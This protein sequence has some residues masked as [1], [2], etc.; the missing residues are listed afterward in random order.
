MEL[1]CY[2][3]W[4]AVLVSQFVRRKHMLKENMVMSII[5]CSL[6]TKS[7]LA[8]SNLEFNHGLTY[9]LTYQVPS[10]F[11]FFLLAGWSGFVS[12]TSAKYRHLH[13]PTPHHPLHTFLWPTGAT[14]SRLWEHVVNPSCSRSSWPWAMD[15]GVSMLMC[16]KTDKGIG[17]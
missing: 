12:G 17:L 11:F 9:L 5:L 3:W 15:P 7:K 2:E 10:V 8:T 14:V 6:A 13:P 4:D 1:L 16:G